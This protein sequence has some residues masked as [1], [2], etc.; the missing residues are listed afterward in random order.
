MD[1]SHMIAKFHRTG[2]VICSHLRK[3]KSHLIAEYIWYAVR[4]ESLW[5]N[6]PGADQIFDF[7]NAYLY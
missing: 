4:S 3:G 5:Q 1:K 2:L 7:S 6:S